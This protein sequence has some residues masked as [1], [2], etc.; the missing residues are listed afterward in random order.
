MNFIHEKRRL[1]TF[2][3]FISIEGSIYIAQDNR[4][5][6]L[7]ENQYLILYADHEH[8]EYKKSN[9]PVS[10]YWCH[11]KVPNDNYRIINNTDLVGRFSSPQILDKSISQFYILPEH[12]DLSGNKRALLMFRQLLDISRNSFYTHNLPNYALSLLAMEVSQEF[13]E[14]NFPVE[15]N[16]KINPKLEKIIEWIRINYNIPMTLEKIGKKFNY[17]PDYLST[18]FRKYKGV[19]LMKYILLVRID[20]AKKLL[21]NSTDSVKEIAYKTGFLDD[22]VLMKQF[23]KLEDAT[24]TNFRNAFSHVKLVKTP[25]LKK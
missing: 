8:Y 2:V 15:K 22:R 7:K 13:I 10:Y 5:F 19:S 14:L 25:Q 17:N 12:G 23:K 16:K 20:A 6:I 1:D 9:T 11:F 3:I 18:S 4:Q 21:L 24:P